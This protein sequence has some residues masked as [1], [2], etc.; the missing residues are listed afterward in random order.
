MNLET[1]GMSAGW[2]WIKSCGFEVTSRIMAIRFFFL[3]LAIA[4]VRRI[5][6]KVLMVIIGVLRL[7]TAKINTPAFWALRVIMPLLVLLTATAVT[8]YAL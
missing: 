8:V 2:K 3:L 5:A 6:I 4:K 7:T 1:L